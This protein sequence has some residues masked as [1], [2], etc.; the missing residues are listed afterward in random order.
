L[1][2]RRGQ[3]LTEM[4]FCIV[5]CRVPGL[6]QPTNKLCLLDYREYRELKYREPSDILAESEGTKETTPSL[7]I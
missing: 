2:A 4:C 6:P 1:S 3:E 7:V 5:Q